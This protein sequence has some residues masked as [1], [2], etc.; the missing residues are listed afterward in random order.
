[1]DAW[2][3][4]RPGP[5]RKTP[6]GF[7][8]CE[9]G[10]LKQRQAIS[11]MKTFPSPLIPEGIDRDDELAG[12][13]AALDCLNAIG[14]LLELADYQRR[15]TPVTE[16]AILRCLYDMDRAFENSGNFSVCNL[17]YPASLPAPCAEAPKL[18]GE[19]RSEWMKAVVEWKNLP[20][21]PSDGWSSLW[22]LYARHFGDSVGP[23]SNDGEFSVERC[24]ADEKGLRYTA[25]FFIPQIAVEH[26]WHFGAW[27]F[28]CERLK[29]FDGTD[30][31]ALAQALVSFRDRSKEPRLPPSSGIVPQLDAGTTERSAETTAATEESLGDP[32]KDQHRE[33]SA[34]LGGPKLAAALGVHISRRDAFVKQLERERG[35]LMGEGSCVEMA[36]RRPNTSQYL[37]RIDSPLILSIAARYR[38]PKLA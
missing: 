35:R 30:L 1:M 28:V 32:S 12:C 3:T 23:T 18:A 2:H 22:D 13:Q 26:Q 7:T 21:S 16:A 37:Y 10:R 6:F 11:L 25:R 5:A 19:V 33:T 14:Q 17:T 8:Q 27:P 38:E 31:I 34:F 29:R 4:Q 36:E 24:D 15:G 20:Q 9:P